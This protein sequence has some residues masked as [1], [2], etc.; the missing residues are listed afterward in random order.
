MSVMKCPSEDPQ[1][2][3][4]FSAFPSIELQQVRQEV[5]LRFSNRGVIHYTIISNQLHRRALGKYTD[6]K[7]FSDEML[8]SLMRKVRHFYTF[9]I[10]S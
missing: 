9:H 8:L 7:M 4:D 1:I 6:F 10:T 2:K 5:P 3:Q